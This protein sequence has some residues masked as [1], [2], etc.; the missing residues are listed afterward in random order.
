MLIRPAVPDDA[1]AVARVHVRSWQVGYRGLLPVDFLESLRPEDRAA[2]YDFSHADP[3][4]PHTFVAEIDDTIVGLASTMPS[5]DLLPG[6]GELCALYVDPS[7]WGR[8][9]GVAL[10]EVARALMVQQGFR[11]AVLWLLKGNA[12]GEGFYRR[13]GW[14]PDG[15][16]KTDRVWGIDVEDFRYVRPLL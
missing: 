9:I 16:R 13:D 11:S 7:F 10:I 14:L 8:G 1:L 3:Q 5:Q 2:R 6:Q 12:R 4:K 15:A